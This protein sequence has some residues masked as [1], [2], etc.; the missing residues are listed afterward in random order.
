MRRTQPVPT[1]SPSIYR[2]FRKAGR[3]QYRQYKKANTDRKTTYMPRPSVCFVCPAPGYCLFSEKKITQPFAIAFPQ[4]PN[5][6]IL[7]IQHNSPNEISS[8]SPAIETSIR[9]CA[10]S[11][12]TYCKNTCISFALSLSQKALPFRRLS[13][14]VPQER[15]HVWDPA[16]P[17]VFAKTRSH[18]MK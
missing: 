3:K 7:I 11:P 6:R 16:S 15:L 2:A 14:D 5:A 13:I 8:H 18:L 1:P 12:S 17:V 10:A 9:F 4:V